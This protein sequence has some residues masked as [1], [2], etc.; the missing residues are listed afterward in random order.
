MA[1]PTEPKAKETLID[2]APVVAQ[3]NKYLDDQSAAVREKAIP[4][5]GYQKAALI[6]E[7]ELAQIR[8]FEKT[9]ADQLKE[10]GQ[11]YALLSSVSSQNFN[12][13]TRSRTSLSSLKTGFWVWLLPHFIGKKNSDHAGNPDHTAI[14]APLDPNVLFGTFVKLLQKD[15]EYI[16]L[17]SAKI[18]ATLAL[19]RKEPS[20]PAVDVHDL[21]HWLTVK[22]TDTN[23]NVVDIAIQILQTLL[24]VPAYRLAFYQ[25]TGAVNNLIDAVKNNSSNPQMQYQGIYCMWT[26]T[27]VQEIAADIQ[28]S[29]EVIPL[30]IDVAKS[31]IKEKVVRV[32]FSTIKNMLTLAPQENIIPMLGNK[33]L[34]LTET[35][36]ARKWSDTE[37]AEDLTFIKEELAKNIN[38]LSTFD[39]YASEVRS[40]KLDW[41]PPHLSEEF[42]KKNAARLGEKDNELVKVLGRL[43]LAPSSSV[44]VLAVAA[45]DVGQYVKYA[46]AGKKY[47]ALIAVQ[48]LMANSWVA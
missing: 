28:R 39:E 30:F 38:S 21:F 47:Q 44:L 3:H 33:L 22:L 34:Q 14:V 37:I 13:T 6:T 26:M 31:A 20:L 11:K 5:E 19:F 45:H 40:G 42:W 23:L 48:K 12:G 9:P 27:F 43:I 36:S 35:L 29:Y 4:W 7:E 16:Q 1:S 10:A 24:A 17:K 46:P 8:L 15:D 32:I 2:I 25:T 41:S 18:F